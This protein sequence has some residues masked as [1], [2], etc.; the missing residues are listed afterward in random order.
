MNKKNI[1]FTL[2]EIIIIIG[3]IGIIAELTIPPVIFG[4]Q[5]QQ[6]IL[7]LKKFYSNLSQAL[8]EYTIDNG[9]PGD[10]LGTPI[11]SSSYADITTLLGSKYF[12]TQKVCKL[13]SNGTECW[14]QKIDDS[15]PN[16]HNATKTMT[17]VANKMGM[18]TSDGMTVLVDYYY[19][20]CNYNECIYLYVDVNGIKGP[21]AYGR[22]Y[23]RLIVT[24]NLKIFGTG[25][26]MI[27]PAY[28]SGGHH[29]HYG[30]NNGTWKERCSDEGPYGK[31]SPFFNGSYCSARPIEEGWQMNY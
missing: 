18:I 3:I 24:R 1:A 9:T 7:G 16:G 12:K 13:F 30:N 28:D 21:N 23:F 6:Y 11:F 20:D 10:L 31:I 4:I 5:K 29:Y 26:E 17:S 27:N 15:G 22:D 19:P 2:A 25:T 8:L 14:P